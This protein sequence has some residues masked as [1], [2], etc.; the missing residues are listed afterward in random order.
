VK[1]S[2]QYLKLVR[3]HWFVTNVPF[4]YG[5]IGYREREHHTEHD[6]IIADL[7]R[8]LELGFL[9]FL[10]F[11]KVESQNRELTIQNAL[12]RL[13]ARAL[14]MQKAKICSELSAY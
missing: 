3:G 8:G 5:M 4:R 6:Q 7:A 10:D 13:R 2:C 9:R 14:G 11:Q 12:E 1:K